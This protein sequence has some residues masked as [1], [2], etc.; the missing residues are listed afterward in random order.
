M[1]TFPKPYTGLRQ[2]RFEKW[3]AIHY[4]ISCTLAFLFGFG[5]FWFWYWVFGPH[6]RDCDRVHCY[7]HKSLITLVSRQDQHFCFCQWLDVLA[8]LGSGDAHKMN[9]VSLGKETLEELNRLGAQGINGRFYL[10]VPL[11]CSQSVI[12]QRDAEGGPRGHNCG[13]RAGNERNDNRNP[14]HGGNVPQR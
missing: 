4:A 10:C 13:E 14:V 1:P 2:A 8:P 3:D 11:A 12:D 6:V 7:T 9:G 5:G